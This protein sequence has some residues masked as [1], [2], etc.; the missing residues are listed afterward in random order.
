MAKAFQ[1]KKQHLRR[2]ATAFS[3]Y[4][5]HLNLK[6]MSSFIKPNKSKLQ[7]S[8]H[9]SL[10]EAF[11]TVLAEYNFS[12]AKLVALITA[13]LTCFTN[14]DHWYMQARASEVIARRNVADLLRDKLYTKL[15]AL[16]R[17][18]LN[19]GNS[20]LEAAA[21]ALVRVFRLYAVNTSAQIDAE[22]GQMDNLITDLSTT[23][24]QANIEAIGGKWLFDEM[25]AAHE[26]VKSIRLEQGQEESEKVVGALRKAR[27]ESDA[28]YDA[29]LAAIEAS[30]ILAD[31]PEPYE[32]F[33]RR[34]NGTLKIY[35]DMLDRKSGNST[36]G[37]AN[38]DG[39]G[40][41]SSENENDNDNENNGGTNQGGSGTGTITPGGGDTSGSGDNNNPGGGGGDDTGSDES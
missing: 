30:V 32:A 2:M 26:E 9:Y 13:F 29:I 21:E 5:N 33:I 38:P 10:M 4:F 37:T 3:K 1:A 20:V 19:S 22:S 7:N 15:F 31:N 17:I 14:E 40:N 36:G 34:W 8:Q 11:K 23:A 24:M 41:G 12:A 28:A 25:K 39:T 18:W 6:I 35:Q 27:K 16:V